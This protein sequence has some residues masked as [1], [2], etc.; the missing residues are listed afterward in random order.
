ML[1]LGIGGSNVHCFSHHIHVQITTC[2]ENAAR[3]QKISRDPN[4]CPI[5]DALPYI[6]GP[7]SPSTTVVV[8]VK[9]IVQGGV[10]VRRDVDKSWETSRRPKASVTF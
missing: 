3:S 7:I 4:E 1:G 10:K 5:G 9:V 2:G 6:S 8:I